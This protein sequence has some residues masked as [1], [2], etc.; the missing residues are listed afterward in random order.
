MGKYGASVAAFLGLVWE[1]VGASLGLPWGF[2]GAS[3]LIVHKHTK[4]A[5]FFLFGAIAFADC[6]QISV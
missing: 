4:I 2:L 6:S 1:L 3:A 5:Q